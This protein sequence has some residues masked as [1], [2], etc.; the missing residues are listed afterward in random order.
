MST[1]SIK[2]ANGYFDPYRKYHYIH[3]EIRESY[4]S[5]FLEAHRASMERSIP[6]LYMHGY[7]DYFGSLKKHINLAVEGVLDPEL[8]LKA[9]ANDWNRV[10]EELGQDAQQLQWNFLRNSYPHAIQRL[11]G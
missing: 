11:M 4:G 9:T 8:A 3:P 7:S 10:T 1:N 6:D 5:P 2:Q